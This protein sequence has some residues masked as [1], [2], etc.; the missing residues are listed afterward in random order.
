MHVHT[1]YLASKYTHNNATHSGGCLSDMPLC[2]KQHNACCRNMFDT[3]LL[4]AL[5]WTDNKILSITSAAGTVVNTVTS[6][7]EGSQFESWIPSNSLY[8]WGVCFFYLC[9]CGFPPASSHSS[10][11]CT[12]G[13]WLIEDSKLMLGVN[14]C[15]SQC[16]VQPVQDSPC[17]LPNSSWYVN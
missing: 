10:K 6:Q 14:G 4:L 1:D 2:Y 9:L 15:L 3:E 7:Q 13:L 16:V 17:L 5:L 8:L 12:L 11:K